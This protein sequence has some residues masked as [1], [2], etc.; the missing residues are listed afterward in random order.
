MEG[1]QFSTRARANL[2]RSWGCDVIGMTNMPE[3]KLA[4]EAEICLRDRRHGDRLRLLARGARRGRHRLGD[5]GDGRERRQGA[6]P[7]SSGSPATSRAST[8]HARSGPTAR[9]RSPSSRRRRR[10]TFAVEE[11]R[12]GPSSRTPHA[13][14]APKPSVIGTTNEPE[15][16]PHVEVVH[17]A[18]ARPRHGT[19]LAKLASRPRRIRRGSIGCAGSSSRRRARA[20]PARGLA[21][22]PQRAQRSSSVLAHEREVH[23]RDRHRFLPRDVFHEPLGWGVANALIL[24]SSYPALSGY[25][26]F[27]PRI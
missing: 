25:C 2:Y 5:P 19:D 12:R 6:A 9:S 8:R 21:L 23:L 15:A 20:P 13:T 22:A 14:P 26:Y 4:R 27:A 10:A 1:P 16:K 18:S 7:R 24:A 3:A 11:A 17:E